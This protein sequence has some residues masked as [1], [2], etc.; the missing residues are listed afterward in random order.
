[1]KKPGSSKRGRGFSTWWNPQSPALQERPGIAEGIVLNCRSKL[2]VSW[3]GLCGF[4]RER[5]ESLGP[6]DVAQSV[7]LGVRQ[8]LL[9]P[10]FCP[11]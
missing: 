6:E 10:C 8:N 5:E 2:E 11:L 1:M 9:M 4:L 3:E 7:G